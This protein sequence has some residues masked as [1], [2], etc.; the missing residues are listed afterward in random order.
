M[1]VTRDEINEAV[2]AFQAELDRDAPKIAK[3]LGLCN[4]ADGRRAIALP[5]SR[6]KWE[7]TCPT[8]E[9]GIEVPMGKVNGRGEAFVPTHTAA[10]N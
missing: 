8:C 3:A 9:A 10:V 6:G 4:G 5:T 1:T 7:V 2:K